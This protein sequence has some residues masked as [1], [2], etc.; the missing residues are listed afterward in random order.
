MNVRPKVLS[1]AAS[2]RK[3]ARFGFT[4]IESLVAIAIIAI[5][6]ARLLPALATAKFRAKV[7]DYTSNYR[8]WAVAWMTAANLGLE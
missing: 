4:L 5:L 2:F 8:Q 3:Y 6:A 1:F 7:K